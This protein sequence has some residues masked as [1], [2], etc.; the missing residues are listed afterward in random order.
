MAHQPQE[1]TV[2]EARVSDL[3]RRWR[4]HQSRGIRIAARLDFNRVLMAAVSER[5]HGQA[6][7]EL[8]LRRELESLR[9]ERLAVLN[10]LDEHDAWEGEI[11]AEIEA[12]EAEVR[13]VKIR[14]GIIREGER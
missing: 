4:A 3:Q 14:Y 6:V 5:L 2:I 9:V 12:I 1:L 10:D 7:P 8:R 13:R 11:G